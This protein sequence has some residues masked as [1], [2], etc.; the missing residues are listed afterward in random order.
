MEQPKSPQLEI[1]SYPSENHNFL[2][3]VICKLATPARR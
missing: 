3:C 2:S 1:F